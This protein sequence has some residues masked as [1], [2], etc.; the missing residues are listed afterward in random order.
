METTDRGVEARTTRR[1]LIA[2]GLGTLAAAAVGRP[3]AASASDGDPLVLGEENAANRTTSIRNPSRNAV[4]LQVRARGSGGIAVDGLC[5]RGFAIHGASTHGTGV[6]G[7]SVFGAALSGHAIEP[8]SVGVDG[9]ANAGVG[10]R[11]G[12][13]LDAGVLGES[14]Y[15]IAVSGA[16][17]SENAPAIRGWAQNGQ[18]GVLGLST[19]LGGDA[20][21][22]PTNVGV[23]GV[24][25]ASDGRGVL[26]RSS[27]GVALETDGR[28]RFSTSG[29]ATVPSGTAQVG[30]SAP[31][32][33]TASTK[34]LAM[35]RSNPGAVVVRWVE[36]DAAANTFT[37]H[38]SGS[39]S[40]DTS[41]AWF[42]LE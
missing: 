34:I 41:V 28:V 14:Q 3:T 42:A 31:F 11:G 4:T 20:V 25:D 32:D 22:S 10:V 35:P 12:S 38:M 7:E 30:V 40:S 18:T 19:P 37:I 2:G 15:D 1:A 17:I 8:G 27:D 33:V 29:I 26:A 36:I 16:N 21:A 24:C 5:H 23:F 9:Y 13:D 6:A 39:V